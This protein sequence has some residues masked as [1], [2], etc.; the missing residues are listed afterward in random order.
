M[1]FIVLLRCPVHTPV[2][3]PM[4]GLP[5]NQSDQNIRS[6]FQ[7]MYNKYTYVCDREDI[8]SEATI[9]LCNLSAA[10]EHS[11]NKIITNF[12][13]EVGPGVL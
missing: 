4:Y 11:G 10:I 6:V 13:N 12:E 2:R 5:L 1:L 9:T 8:A 3:T 7:S